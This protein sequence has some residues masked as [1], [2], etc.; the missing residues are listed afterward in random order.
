M[1]WSFSPL[2]QVIPTASSCSF[3]EQRGG[4]S[5]RELLKSLQVISTPLNISAWELNLASHPDQ[6]F[7]KFVPRGIKYGFRLGFDQ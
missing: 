4:Q 2:N 6:E 5:A 7:T 1:H 3:L